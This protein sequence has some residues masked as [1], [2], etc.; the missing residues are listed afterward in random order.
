[1]SKSMFT[2]DKFF[3]CHDTGNNA[4][5][6]WT[7]SETYGTEHRETRDSCND[8]KMYNALWCTMAVLGWVPVNR[9]TT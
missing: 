3:S 5:L 1:M 8:L 7:K 4:P 9:G 2:A 6:M